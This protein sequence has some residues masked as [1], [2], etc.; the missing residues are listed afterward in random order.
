MG[1][2]KNLIKPSSKNIVKSFYDPAGAVKGA[3]KDSK[4][5]PVSTAADAALGDGAGVADPGQYGGDSADPAYGSLNQ[6]FGVEQFYENADPGYAFQ[7]QQGEQ[8]VLNSAAVGGSALGGPALK[9]LMKWNQDYAGTAYNDAFNRYTTQQ[10]NTFS[11]LFQLTQ[12]GQNAAAGVGSQGTALAG[13]A[14]QAATNA[15]SAYGA[16]IVGAGNAAAGGL[17]NAWLYGTPSGRAAWQGA[18]AAGKV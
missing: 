16:G 7:L 11:R 13:N 12:L 14:G 18:P 10:N 3:Y 9:D 15:G 6:P 17:T 5:G 1:F 4:K 2:L 8:G